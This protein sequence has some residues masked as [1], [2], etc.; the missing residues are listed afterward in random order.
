MFIGLSCFKK[1]Y[2]KAR[3]FRTSLLAFPL[4]HFIVDVDKIQKLDDKT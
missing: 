4:P 2:V 3:P 1:F